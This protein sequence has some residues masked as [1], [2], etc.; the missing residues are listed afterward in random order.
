MAGNWHEMGTPPRSPTSSVAAR[1][2]TWSS[3]HEPLGTM[4]RP[5]SSAAWLARLLW[6]QEVGSSNLPSPTRR[7][8]LAHQEPGVDGAQALHLDRP[9]NLELVLPVEQLPRNATHLHPARDAV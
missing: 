3:A 2:L 4:S 5:G 6:E 9:P 1:R 7:A 8:L